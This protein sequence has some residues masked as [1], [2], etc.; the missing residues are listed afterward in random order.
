LKEVLPKVSR[1]AFLNDGSTEQGAAS[2][3]AFK[4]AQSTAKFLAAQFQLVEVKAPNPD[5]DGAFRFMV[6]NR[7]GALVTSPAPLITF[8]RKKI[9]ESTEKNRIPAIHSG[10]QWANEGGLMSYGTNTDEQ[11]RRAAVFV[12]KIFIGANPAELPVEGPMKF[13]FVINLQAAKKIGVTV[14]QS[15]LFRADKVIK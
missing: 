13:E 5:F 15:V 1:F 6:K 2:A 14:P 10:Q 4:D 3:A 8:H 12:D 9:L 11:S 7:I